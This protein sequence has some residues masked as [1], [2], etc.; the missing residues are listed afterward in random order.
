VLVYQGARAVIKSCVKILDDT[1][2]P[3]DA[4]VPPFA[5]MHGNPGVQV[6][7]LPESAEITLRD[8]AVAAIDRRR[9]V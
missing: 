6:G 1:V 9:R 7:T 8:L 3:A 4:V 5:I 2:I